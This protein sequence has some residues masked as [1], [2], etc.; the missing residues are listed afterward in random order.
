MNYLMG[1]FNSYLCVGSVTCHKMALISLKLFSL[2]SALLIKGAGSPCGSVG[3]CAGDYFSTKRLDD[4]IHLPLLKLNW[5]EFFE[6]YISLSA[7][8]SWVVPLI[9]TFVSCL[10]YVG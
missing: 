7:S 3:G 4:H 6:L 8:E 2:C 10:V 5:T 1:S 9:S